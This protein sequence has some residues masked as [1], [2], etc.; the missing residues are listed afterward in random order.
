VK[1]I[2]TLAYDYPLLSIFW[3]LLIFAGFILIFVLMV[4]ALLDNFRRKGHGWS[5]VGWTLVILIP[6][7]G[8]LI[9]VA[10]RPSYV[11]ETTLDSSMVT[12][13]GVPIPDAEG[14]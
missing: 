8:A 4:W 5:K 2:A 3:T 13:R 9:Y 14:F 1:G 12:S 7:L 10:M 6:L 11:D